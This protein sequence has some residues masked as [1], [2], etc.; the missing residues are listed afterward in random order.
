MVKRRGLFGFLGMLP[1]VPAIAAAAPK[2]VAKPA[3]V[4]DLSALQGRYR[5]AFVEGFE[6]TRIRVRGADGLFLRARTP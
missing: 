4:D 5:A 1:V 2:A 3:K 6:Q